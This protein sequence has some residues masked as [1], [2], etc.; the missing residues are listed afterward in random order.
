MKISGDLHGYL[1]NKNTLKNVQPGKWDHGSV[2]RIISVKPMHRFTEYST[3]PGSLFVF[4]N[5]RFL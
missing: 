4:V 1:G 3:P 2:E 5:V